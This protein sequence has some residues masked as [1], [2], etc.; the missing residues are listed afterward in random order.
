[1]PDIVVKSGGLGD[2]SDPDIVMNIVFN[3]LMKSERGQWLKAYSRKFSYKFDN[4]DYGLT[5]N[6]FADMND[7]TAMI[8]RLTWGKEI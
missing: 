1:M 4:N 2:P 7:H 6:I 5:Y 8:Y 3:E